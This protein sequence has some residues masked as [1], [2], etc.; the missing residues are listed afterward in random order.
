[1]CGYVGKFSINNF[2]SED[3]Y[4]ANRFNICRGPD[5]LQTLEGNQNKINYSMVFNRLSILDL[6]DKA[7]Q[8]MQDGYGN[9][10]MFNGEIYNHKELR[11]YLE[12]RNIKFTSNHSDTETLLHGLKL[13]GTKFLQMAIGQFSIMYLNKNENTLTL[14]R[15]RVGQKP[16]F[17]YKNSQDLLISTNLKAILK[18]KRDF[19]IRDD[20]LKEYFDTGVISAPNTLFEEI[21]K[22]QP[23]EVV[24]FSIE[25]N[26]RHKK[27]KFWSISDTTLTDKKPFIQEE[28]KELLIDSVKIRQNADVKVANLLSGGIDSTTILKIAKEN[29]TSYSLNTFS[30]TNKG[31]QYDETKWINDVITKYDIS[32]EKVDI[33][34]DNVHLDLINE[35][36]EAFD[37][38]YSDPSTV[39][40]Y[41][42]YKEI[43]KHYKVAVSGDGGDEL[44]GGY[45]RIL[46][47]LNRSKNKRS[48]LNLYPAFLGS[49]NKLSI[50]QQN[51]DDAYLSFF[52][53][54]KFLKLLN[55]ESY[56]LEEKFIDFEESEYLSMINFDYRYYL[57]EMMML[58][59]DRASMANSVEIR[60]PFV[61]HRLI[62]YMLASNFE[63]SN[64][65]DQKNP[66]KKIL[67]EDFTDT[68]INRKKMGFVFDLKKWIYGNSQYLSDFFNKE[69]NLIGNLNPNIISTLSINKSNMNAQR[70]WR[71]YFIEKYLNSLKNL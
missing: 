61:D 22:L 16:L 71:I 34:V 18:L 13:L 66:L 23:G 12:S 20:S 67:S 11:D 70:I 19:N 21:Y 2:Y 25:E 8:P 24:T 10:I 42:I 48:Y 53:D 44:L 58:K 64:N 9:I 17:Y 30:I 38:P 27:Q 39:P 7:A 49:G 29:T 40:S 3:V 63:V 68:F 50:N 45:T 57:P 6:T 52:K 31:T 46:K 55:L 59:V 37:E 43:S 26:F 15:D 54:P 62:E 60:S 32:Y 36:I 28:F 65:E 47:T 41:I 1:M 33:D 51:L 4:Q 69:S 56:N 14:V 5:D 35:S